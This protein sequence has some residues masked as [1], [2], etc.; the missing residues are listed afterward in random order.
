MTQLTT[1]KAVLPPGLRL[2]DALQAILLM[3][4]RP[5]VM[6][7][8]HKRHGDVFSVRMPYGP[9]GSMVTVVALANPEDIRQVFAGNVAIYHA[10]EGNSSLLDVMGEHSLLL[11]DE[12][13]HARA[14]KLLTPAFTTGALNGYRP[15]FADLA[16]AEIA[17]WPDGEEFAAIGRM[18]AITLEIILRVV[19]GVTEPERLAELRPLVIKIANLDLVMLLA[20]RYP[21]LQKLPP[22]RGHA[23]AQQELD[24]LLYAEIAERRADPTTPVRDDLLSRLLR[25]SDDGDM[26]SDAELRDQLITFLLAGHE[27]TATALSWALHELAHHPEAMSH[28]QQAADNPSHEG[29][30]YLEAVVKEAMRLRPVI[31]QATRTLTEDTNVAGYRLPAGVVVSPALGLVG[32]SEA[33]H[34][35]AGDFRPDRFLAANPAPNTWIPFGGGPRR[36]IGAAFSLVE[37]VEILRELLRAYEIEPVRRRPERLRPRGII[38]APSH[39]SRIRLSARAS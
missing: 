14:R 7:R 9:H 10:G 6:R 4:Y 11:L 27:T 39:G 13:Q 18:Q 33:L 24:D 2:P 5:T 36:C 35:D 20:W 12:S 38:N 22:W 28:A 16:R 34:D 23:A 29:D 17:G 3:R 32:L 8:L 1:T 21:K 26:L 31:F 25:P 15:M 37:S 19:F 30:K